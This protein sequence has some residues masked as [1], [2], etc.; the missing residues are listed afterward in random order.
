MSLALQRRCRKLWPQ[1]LKKLQHSNIKNQALDANLCRDWS[2]QSGTMW[3]HGLEHQH[4]LSAVMALSE[5]PIQ[6]R[7][8]SNQGMGLS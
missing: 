7:L 2:K 8:L 3:R 5:W 4:I 6:T 1:L